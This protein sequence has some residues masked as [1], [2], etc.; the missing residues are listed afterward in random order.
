MQISDDGSFQRLSL[1]F[2][3]KG[4]KFADDDKVIDPRQGHRTKQL[5]K[6]GAMRGRAL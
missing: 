1:N 4:R 3:A 5:S 2:K 6:R